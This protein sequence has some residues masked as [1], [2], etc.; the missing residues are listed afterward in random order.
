MGLYTSVNAGNTWQPM[1][2]GIP[3]TPGAR[4]G[5]TAIEIDAAVPQTMYIAAGVWV[6]TSHVTFHPLGILKTTDGGA[7]WTRVESE[8]GRTIEA[9]LLDGKTLHTWSAGQQTSYAIH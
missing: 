3:V 1:N 2:T 5:I 9:M 8:T 6:G 7:T 4:F